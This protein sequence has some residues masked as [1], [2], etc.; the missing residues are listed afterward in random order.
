M[1]GPKWP[2]GRLCAHCGASFLVQSPHPQQQYCSMTCAG[3][4]RK[5][6]GWTECP[7]CEQRFPRRK[8]SQR[9]CSVECGRV[10]VTA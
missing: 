8:A 7:T 1:I 9:F 3:F 4:G 6:I 2:Q 5:R 10:K